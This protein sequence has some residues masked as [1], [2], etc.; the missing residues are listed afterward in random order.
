MDQSAQLLIGAVLSGQSGSA[1]LS[2]YRPLPAY[3]DVDIQQWVTPPPDQGSGVSVSFGPNLGD[4]PVLSD[5]ASAGQG[6]E[7][8]LPAAGNPSLFTG[9]GAVDYLDGGGLVLWAQNPAV[10]LGGDVAGAASTLTGQVLT[11]LQAPAVQGAQVGADPVPLARSL[12]EGVQADWQQA[13]ARVLASLLA[14][15]TSA[16]RWQMVNQLPGG[17]GPSKPPPTPSPWSGDLLKDASNL[18]AGWSDKLTFGMTARI[19][20]GLNYDDVVD[21]NSAAYALGSSIGQ[22]HN[23]LLMVATGG[24][25]GVLGTA[26]RGL[27]AAAVIGSTMNGV[28]AL[29]AGDIWSVPSSR[30]RKSAW[31]RCAGHQC[32]RAG[33]HGGD[34][35]ATG[36]ARG[37]GRRRGGGFAGQVRGRRLFRRFRGP[38]GCRGQPL[39]GHPALLRC[40]HAAVD[41]DGAQGN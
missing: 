32:L 17:V 29:K 10:P 15:F 6:Y 8:S 14:R 1:S 26:E 19:R 25:A 36:P 37:G 41:A 20:S 33:D 40:G 27:Q 21:K 5:T 34:V 35:A 2:W 22:L 11:L 7:A 28:E 12:G 23:D 30:S 13:Q 39:H 38:G 18:F 31:W 9:T 24:A 3:F 4:A 16:A